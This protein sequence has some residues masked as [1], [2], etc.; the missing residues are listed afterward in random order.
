MAELRREGRPIYYT[1][2]TWLN[3]GHA[4]THQWHF[5]GVH[6]RPKSSAPGKGQRLIIT[7][8]GSKDGFLAGGE[9]TFV[10]KTGDGDYH[11]EM[12]GEV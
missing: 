6:A 12:N 11:R 8:I 10:S 2:E 4:R 5:E 9:L 7:D 1:D 3:T